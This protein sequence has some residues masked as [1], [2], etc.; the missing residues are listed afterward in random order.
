MRAAPPCG[1][2][3]LTFRPTARPPA[4]TLL[5]VPQEGLVPTDLL[6]GPHALRSFVQVPIGT[7]SAPMGALLL[8]KKETESF[9]GHWYASCAEARGRAGANACTDVCLC[10]RV[11]CAHG[12]ASC[13]AI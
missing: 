4:L 1:S 10:A 8:A 2:P 6:Q 13:A 9:D 5:P 3:A 12:A 11:Y 7:P